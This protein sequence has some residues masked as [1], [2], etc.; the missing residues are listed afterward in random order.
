MYP[1]TC[2]ICGKIFSTKFCPDCGRKYDEIVKPEIITITTYIHGSKENGYN[3]CEKYDVDPK[4]KLGQKLVYL[5]CEVKL[6][7][8]II[9]DK[10]II[11]QINAGD[12]QKLCN[13]VPIKKN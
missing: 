3:L 5:N 11:K 9:D 12:G 7:Y 4:S 8:E 2:D 1:K 6:I 10:L 13:V